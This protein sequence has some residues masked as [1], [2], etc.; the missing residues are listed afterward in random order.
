MIF[1]IIKKLIQDFHFNHNY[2]IL[3]AIIKNKILIFKVFKILN[4]KIYSKNQK[5][6]LFNNKELEMN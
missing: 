2:L 1:L 4:K 5:I 3:L 6:K